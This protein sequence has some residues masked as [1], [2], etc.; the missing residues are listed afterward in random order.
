MEHYKSQVLS[1]VYVS[2]KEHNYNHSRADP[3]R[4]TTSNSFEKHCSML[5]FGADGDEV[6][7]D[8]G[9][10]Q[11]SGDLIISSNTAL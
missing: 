10:A 9:V 7:V 6:F 1:S 11:M 5:A 4:G 2:K 8:I 3:P